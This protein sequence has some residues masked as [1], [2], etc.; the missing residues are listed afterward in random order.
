M[1]NVVN[2]S[3][4]EEE[5]M[6]QPGAGEWVTSC[7]HSSHLLWC[8]ISGLVKRSLGLGAKAAPIRVGDDGHA[9]E[10]A[11][12]EHYQLQKEGAEVARPSYSGIHSFPDTTAVCLV[13]F[14][15]RS[16]Q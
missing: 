9:L 13:F 10:A 15:P 12:R 11:P 1:S 16:F 5:Q 6:P 7:R 2:N 14:D 3:G 4:K 8:L